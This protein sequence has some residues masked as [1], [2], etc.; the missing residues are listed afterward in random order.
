[1]SETTID[2]VV[3]AN[4]KVVVT[5]ATGEVAYEFSSV[6]YRILEELYGMIEQ[7]RPVS[8][9]HLCSH[10]LGRGRTVP[11]ADQ[12]VARGVIAALI[13][14]GYIEEV[15]PGMLTCTDA[16]SNAFFGRVGD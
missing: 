9:D 3:H 13:D 8:I 4:N 12:S 11:L 16:G 7:D 10:Y 2:R 6:E 5:T 15:A 14:R 1:M